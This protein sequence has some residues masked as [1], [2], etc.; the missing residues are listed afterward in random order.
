MSFNLLL[1]NIVLEINSLCE[2]SDLKQ[3]QHHWNICRR[4]DLFAIGADVTMVFKLSM[5]WRRNTQL[6]VEH[7]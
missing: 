6:S 4:L 7:L 5:K 2:C 3:E 1:S